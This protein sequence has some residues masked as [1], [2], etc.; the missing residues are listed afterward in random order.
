MIPTLQASI[1]TIPSNV[2]DAILAVPG[3]R[4]R[5]RTLTASWHATGP[6]DTLLQSVGV[7]A[8]EVRW[9][10]PPVGEASWEEVREALAATGRVKPFVLDGF[11]TG[12]QKE[13]LE[14][15]LLRPGTL[16][17]HPT[18]CLSG[19]TL[20]GV[21]RAG[22][23]FQLSIRDLVARFNGEAGRWA[24][25]IETTARCAMEGAIRLNPIQRAYASGRK[26][27][28]TLTTTTGR[29]IRA[30]ADHKFQT[31]AGFRAL[32]ELREGDTIC[33]AVPFPQGERRAKIL[34]RMIGVRHHPHAVQ[35]SQPRS[36]EWCTAHGYR[37]GY[38]ERSFRVPHHRLV[39]EAAANGLDY[40][41][42]VARCRSGDT[43]GLTFFDPRVFAVHHLD[44]NPKN[45]E[46]LNLAVL[47]H[48]EHAERHG[49]DGGWRR[50][51][52]AVGT[53]TVASIV[54][55]GEEDTYDL[56]MLD[57]FNNYVAN[58]FVVHNSGK[59]VSAILWAV[60]A[61]GATV[62]VTKAATRTQFAR[63]VSR[64]TTLE[65]FA[66][67]PVAEVRKRDRWQSL[68][69][70]LEWCDGDGAQPPWIVV[71]W[72]S[73]SD[74]LSS[75]VALRPHNLVLDESHKGKSSKRWEVLPVAED[76]AAAIASIKARGGF[77]KPSQGGEGIVGILP[78]ENT[79]TA[80]ATLAKAAK[81]R[82]AT[83][84]T[85]ISD[86][87]RDLWGQLDLLEPGAWGSFSVWAKRYA[88][89]KPGLY[90]G[91]DTSGLSNVDELVGRLSYVI[92]RV[93][94]ATTHAQLPAKRR[95][96]MY[97]SAAEQ[98]DAAPGFS[99]EQ[100]AAAAAGASAL[101]EL[102]LAEAAS[103]K[104][105]AVLSRIAEH[106]ESGHK[107]VVFTGRRRDCDD[108]A[109]SIRGACRK[110]TVWCGH[111]GHSQS[112]RA[113]IKAEYIAHPGGCVL[114]GTGEAWG[115]AVD[116]LQCTDAA[117][118]VMLP[119]TPGQLTQ[120]EGRFTRLGQDRPVVIYYVIAEGTVDEHIAD[121]LI[122]KLA[123]S[124][125]V[126]DGG[127]LDGASEALAGLDDP[128]A[129]VASIFGKLG[130]G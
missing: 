5:G 93:D 77:V 45:N 49:R 129:I 61:G 63:E 70:Y 57:P 72:E 88:D 58:G 117:F 32:R 118:F 64:F 103:K 29:T 90:G 56:S 41:A 24:N 6:L 80:T 65:A 42:F 111:G 74:H 15:S 1:P 94:H 12:Y 28:F 22:R 11:L 115:T 27:T 23:S 40:D 53:E 59:T 126:A 79:A 120:W 55:Y 2:T 36:D 13:A 35:V 9:L 113:D 14:F 50:V 8:S 69:A 38:V 39:V 51:T 62:I 119:Y 43:A 46:L 108:L 99:R 124:E 104:R 89:A 33:I 127:S 34:Y 21:N 67:K 60:A 84:A 105:K 87:V 66:L 85:P 102:K 112:E 20:I 86:R 121:V 106:V 75:L 4:L 3:V 19:D 48:V 96:S 83:T 107:V 100:R 26:V 17:H 130:I 101:L 16:Y 25:D 76:D 95:E 125:K 98:V 44:E 71:G 68:D 37:A 128:D 31:P 81:R 123:A 110:A 47:T 10:W 78:R 91:L 92:H 97:V 116:G 114:V 30:T 122:T 52:D 73:L 18:G 54:E 82:L 7:R 109:A